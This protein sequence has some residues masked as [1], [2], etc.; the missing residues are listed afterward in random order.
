[1]V[2][3]RQSPIIGQSLAG[4]LPKSYFWHP[5]G[6]SD[7]KQIYLV[8]AMPLTALA[9][10]LEILRSGKSLVLELSQLNDSMIGAATEGMGG[11]LRSV[12]PA[13]IPESERNLALRPRP[14]P[15]DKG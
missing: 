15:G 14:A 8:L 13:P 1:M 4:P 5:N 11:V 6:T 9:A 12:D 2:S 3:P 10:V 7:P